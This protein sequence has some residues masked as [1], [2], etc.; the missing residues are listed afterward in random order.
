MH[1]ELNGLRS[2]HGVDADCDGQEKCI[3]LTWISTPYVSF[4]PEP[5]LRTSRD[6]LTVLFNLILMINEVAAPMH[7]GAALNFNL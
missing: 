3:V 5:F 1:Q 6:R 4:G 2:H 7:I